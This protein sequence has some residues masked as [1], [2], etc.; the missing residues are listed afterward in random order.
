MIARSDDT[1]GLGTGPAV[2]LRAAKEEELAH[3]HGQV[4]FLRE[5]ADQA[6]EHGFLDVGVDSHPAGGGEDMLHGGFR[7]EDE[8]VD[9]V[10]GMAFFVADAPRDFREEIVVDARK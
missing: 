8:K 2:V 7:S 1:D 10:A 6:V 5:A 4:G 9:H 3:G